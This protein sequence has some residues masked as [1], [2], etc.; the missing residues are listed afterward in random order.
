MPQLVLGPLLRY[1]DDQVATVWVQ[2]DAACEVEILG[3]RARTFCVEDHHF[4]LVAVPGASGPYDVRLDGERVWPRDDDPFPAPSI[5]LIEPGRAIDVVF[6]S[7]RITRPHEPPFVLRG[8]E[9][10][11]GQGVDALRAYALRAAAAG[12]AASLPDLMLMLG[13]QIYADQP[14]PALKERFAARAAERPDDAPRDE[15]ADFTDYADAYFEAWSDPAIRWLLSTVP[16]AMVFDDHEIHA[17]WRISQGWLDEMNAESWFDHHIRAGL[18]AYWVFQHIGNLSPRELADGGL[19]E[20]VVDADD[21]AELL[22]ARMDTAGHQRGHSRWSFARDVGDARLVVIDSRAGRQV[23]PGDRKLISDDEWDW[24]RAQ[25]GDPSR[26]L[27]IASSVP[28][29]LAPGLHHAEAFD[30]ALADGRWGLPKVGEKLRRLGVLDH[31]AS[32]QQTFQR[33][34]ALMDELSRDRDAR[35]SIVLLSGDVH[36]CYLAEVGWREPG[37]AR[38]PVWQAV[39]SAFRKELAPY[40]RAAIMFGHSA[41]GERLARGL[42]RAIGVEPLPLDWRVVEEPAYANQIGTIRLDGDTAALHVEAVDDDWRDPRLHVAFTR[43]LA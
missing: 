32:F 29:L 41:T 11:D 14:S 31:W 35:R 1:V 37:V 30:E 15:L 33:F 10:A 21:A 39:C 26:H 18:A 5:R 38:V 25:A 9:D 12:D 7:C 27:L 20:K 40:E 17:E 23:T 42:S 22:A 43:G 2:A 16:V 28:F 19:Y 13:D 4:A 36:H 34:A 8:H 24:V 3:V 6:G